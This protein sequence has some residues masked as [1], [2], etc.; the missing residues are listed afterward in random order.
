MSVSNSTDNPA[1][2]SPRPSTKRRPG[3]VQK[4]PPRAKRESVED[5]ADKVQ[6]GL[7]GARAAVMTTIMALEGK[8]LIEAEIA[9]NL[10]M[11]ALRQIDVA[12]EWA[13]EV[14]S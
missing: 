12:L 10:R 14:T 13:Q 9:L 6:A 2:K 7:R 5:R 3:L 11:A 8:S 4:A 1:A